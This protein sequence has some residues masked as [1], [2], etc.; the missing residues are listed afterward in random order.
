MDEIDTFIILLQ[1]QVHCYF[2]IHTRSPGGLEQVW[3][4]ISW[5]HL[6]CNYLEMIKAHF[7]KGHDFLGFNIIKKLKNVISGNPH[8]R[9][10]IKMNYQIFRITIA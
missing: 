1:K 4:C 10:V 3:T 8:H 2:Y 7:L 6:Y 5:L 9:N